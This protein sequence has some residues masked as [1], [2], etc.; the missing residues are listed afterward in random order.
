MGYT[1]FKETTDRVT[2]HVITNE[3]GHPISIN[4]LVQLFKLNEGD[5]LSKIEREHYGYVINGG[6][7][8]AFINP[9]DAKNFAI[10]INGLVLGGNN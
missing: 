3:Y 4:T 8:I 9:Q 10:Y 5:L 1:F 6:E 7:K 2:R